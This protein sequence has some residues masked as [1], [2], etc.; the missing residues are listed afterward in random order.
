MSDQS[1]ASLPFLN[2]LAA[3]ENAES[4]RI[5]LRI[6]TDHFIS[7][8]THSAQ[9]LA[10]FE[11]TLLRLLAKSDPATRLIVAR[12]LARHPLAPARALAMIE[13]M[14]GEGGLYVLE[15]APLPRDRLLA[16]ALGN[17]HRAC[18]LARRG[19]LDADL[20]ATLSMR[21]EPEVVLALAENPAA[22]IDSPI[23][24][25]LARRAEREKALAEALLARPGEEADRATLFLLASSDQRAL[26]LAAAQR[27]ELGRANAVAN[28]RDQQAAIAELESHALEREPELFNHVLA[29]ALGCGGDL[30]ERIAKEPSGEPLAVALAALGAPQDVAV[31][32]LISGDLNSGARYTRI[33]SLIRLRE[34][35]NPAA[36]RRVIAA[37]IGAPRERRAQYQ[38]VLDPQAAQTPSRA[39]A[40]RD[41]SASPEAL[42]RQRAF[43]FAAQQGGQ[44]SG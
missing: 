19:D 12:K 41:L 29:Q 1:P 11:K 31:R 9:Q 20:V 16:A 30:A 24:T 28:G 39:G 38:P 17:E 6:T 15:C 7:R 35:L 40:G 5:L 43:A 36:A 22:P 4:R 32:I 21:P 37:L 44:K 2:S 23:L 34:G 27:A 13:E 33:G 42:R 3:S 8:E 26:I 14:G 18:A 25:A 10:Q